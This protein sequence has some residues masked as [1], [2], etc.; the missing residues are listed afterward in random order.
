MKDIPRRPPMSEQEKKD[1]IAGET[2][3]AESNVSLH[4]TCGEC[5][6]APGFRCRAHFVARIDELERALAAK[7]LSRQ[8]DRCPHYWGD[9]KKTCVL[10]VGHD[11]DHLYATDSVSSTPDRVVGTM[12]NDDP[13]MTRAVMRVGEFAP[14]RVSSEAKHSAHVVTVDVPIASPPEVQRRVANRVAEALRTNEAR[15]E[16]PRFVRLGAIDRSDLFVAHPEDEITRAD[17]E[18]RGLPRYERCVDKARPVVTPEEWDAEIEKG[19]TLYLD[20]IELRGVLSRLETWT[21][22]YGAELCPTGADTYGEGVRDSKER[23]KRILETASMPRTETASTQP[24]G[25]GDGE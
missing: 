24:K 10:D 14:G 8:A 13:E 15:P 2:R 4:G 20:N 6:Q 9:W 21:R 22:S 23:V 7:W 1:Y 11:G 12:K 18:L 16:L 25:S 3:E 17:L 19:R 5:G